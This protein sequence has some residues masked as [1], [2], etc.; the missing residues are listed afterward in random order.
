MMPRERVQRFSYLEKVRRG[1]KEGR[2]DGF[3]NKG[4]VEGR[5]S[6]CL[7]VGRQGRCGP[8]GWMVSFWRK[9]E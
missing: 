4:N 6:R 8:R 1:D 9:R 2:G 3:T 5:Q 7:E